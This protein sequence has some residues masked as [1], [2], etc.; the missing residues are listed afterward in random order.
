MTE[1]QRRTDA[2]PDA[3]K[4]AARTKAANDIQAAN[5]EYIQKVHAIADKHG[6]THKHVRNAAIAH[7]RNVSEARAE[8][9]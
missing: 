9:N 1:H 8:Q 7:L 3:E 4:A 6:L 5:E 2:L